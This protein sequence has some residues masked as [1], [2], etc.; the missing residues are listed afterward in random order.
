MTIDETGGGLHLRL[1]P[2]RIND[3]YNLFQ[4]STRVDITDKHMLKQYHYKRL[5][6]YVYNC[7]TTSIQAQK[8]DICRTF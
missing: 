6:R 8:V 5:F 2:V 1:I 4:L 3:S 7:G